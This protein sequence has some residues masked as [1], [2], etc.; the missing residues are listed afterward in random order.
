MSYIKK[1][2]GKDR[3]EFSIN[4]LELFFE[5]EQ[6]ETDVLE[7]KSG[8]VEIEDLYKEITAFLNTEGGLIVVGAPK[9]NKRNKGKIKITMCQGDLTYS[10][11]RSKDWLYQ[12]I[13]SN[14]TPSPTGIKIFE[15]IDENGAIFVID[16][17][18]STTPPHQSSSNG[19]YY[20]RLEREAKAAPHGIVQ[21]LFQ[22][23]RL[24]KLHAGLKVT[25]DSYGS[26]NVIVSLYNQSNIPA[27]KVT[28]MVNVFNVWDIKSEF[29]FKDIV[30]DIFEKKFTLNVSI[31]QPLVQVI[32]APIDFTV[33]HKRKEYLILA[34]YWSK[35]LDYDFQF[36]T[37]N[38]KLEEVTCE[39]RM[40]YKTTS[41]ID[42]IERINAVE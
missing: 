29:D 7:F 38:P 10:K 41:F 20:I 26:D 42:E 15:H 25:T 24:P 12:K 1:I 14:I 28:I 3:E 35:D 36:W 22:K 30:D 27:E 17:P 6:E 39:D 16:I 21:A 37:Y 32:S 2:F 5:S 40:E 9:E 4:D 33:Y 8:D 11:F 34:A 13:M 23:R 18:Q 19:C 31:E